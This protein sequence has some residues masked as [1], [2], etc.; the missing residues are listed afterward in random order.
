MADSELGKR[1]TTRSAVDENTILVSGLTGKTKTKAIV[2]L[3]I[4]I[5]GPSQS[6]ACSSE[7]GQAIIGEGNFPVSSKQ[8]VGEPLF[9]SI[10]FDDTAELNIDDTAELNINDTAETTIIEALSTNCFLITHLL[11]LINV[12]SVPHKIIHYIHLH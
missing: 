1:M 3:S 2:T 5:S 12:T 10:E 4:E 11:S 8:H 6:G 7:E 9:E